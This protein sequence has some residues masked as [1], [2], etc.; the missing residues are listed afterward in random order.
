MSEASIT[1]PAAA[2]G[3]AAH[4]DF[5]RSAAVTQYSLARVFALWAA[6]A[7]PMGV[8][9]WVVAPWLRDQLG[10]RDPFIE[11]L[12]I[13][14]AVGLVWQLVLALILVR[15]EQGSLAWPRARDALWM[16]APRDPKSRRAGGKVWWWVLPFVLLSGAINALPIYPTGPSPRDLPNLLDSDRAEDFFS[17]AWGWFALLVLVALL[18]P[19]VEELFFR[20]LLLPRMRDSFGRADWAANG[21]IFGFYHLHQPWSIPASVVDGIFAQAYPTRRFQSIWIAVAAHTVPSFVIIG[22][23]LSLVLK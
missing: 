9:A 6:V 13:C 8:L 21:A 19:W 20:G 23:V 14:F 18:A 17:G 7:V 2:D 4:E 5:D 16:R 1:T 22:V 12:L 10:G 15:R 3:P 11:A